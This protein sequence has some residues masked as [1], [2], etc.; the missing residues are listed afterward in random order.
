MIWY[1][2]TIKYLCQRDWSVTVSKTLMLLLGN[3]ITIDLINRLKR[4]DDIDTQ[5]LFCKGDLV[6][7]P[8]GQGDIG[9]LSYRY[10]RNLW[11]I[12]ARPYLN[13]NEANNIIEDV[14]SCANTVPNNDKPDINQKDNIYT[15][16]YYELAAYLK[17]LFIYYNDKIDDAALRS[18]S[19][20]EWG[21]YKLIRNAYINTA[22]YNK[23]IIITYNYDI[24]LE[25]ILISNN[26]PFGVSSFCNG[27]ER[28]TILKPHGSI[29]FAHKLKNERSAY[30]IRDAADMYEADTTDFT[31]SYQNLD[32]NYLVNALIPP[33]G[34]SSRLTYR[35]ANKIREDAKRLATELAAEDK[36]IISGLS[37]WHVDRREIDDILTRINRNTCTYLVNPEPPRA[38]NAVLSCI[39]NNY[40]VYTNSNVLGDLK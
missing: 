11:N 21:W 28:I 23:I 5:N 6:P 36:L 31:I 30:S 1:N 27:D 20:T 17:Q 38:L 10:C 37:Y 16:A 34:D 9:F 12:G 29:S 14:L 18:P 19:I 39:Y 7:W 35:W 3:G 33:S 2:K 25:R 40:I 22:E 13:K 4:S 8:D 32:E 24:F 15:L 26:I